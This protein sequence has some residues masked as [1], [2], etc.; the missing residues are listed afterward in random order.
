VL[1]LANHENDFTGGAKMAD[2]KQAALSIL[3]Q[4]GNKSARKMTSELRF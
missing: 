2:K 4:L 3:P 1:L